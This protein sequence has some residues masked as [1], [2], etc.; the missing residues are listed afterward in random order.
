MPIE[1]AGIT[2]N[3]IHRI[4]T[5]EQAGFVRHQ[6]P[7]LEGNL[8]QDLGRNSVHLQVEGI[9][10]GEEA[11]DQLEEIRTLYKNAKLWI[12]WLISWGRPTLPRW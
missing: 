8:V 1:I 12:F 10:Y 9:C 2:L 5:V 6:V 11:Q 4:T 7:G 3:R